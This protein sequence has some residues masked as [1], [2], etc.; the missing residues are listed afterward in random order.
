LQK[1]QELL[2][3]HP[4]SVYALN[5]L[6]SLMNIVLNETCSAYTVDEVDDLVERAL[7]FA[8]EHEHTR[9]RSYLLRMRG[10]IAFQKGYYAQG[11]AYFRMAHE[12]TREIDLLAELAKYQIEVQRLGDAEE[13]LALM[14]QQNDARFG[15]DE[16]QLI[17]S[18]EMLENA[19]REAEQSAE[20]GAEQGDHPQT[21][22]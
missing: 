6:Q 10:L 8:T 13:T 1:S 5:G 22:E 17:L 14:E 4:A 20:Q 21:V 18:R 16:Y 9:N 7:D 11:Y 19:K 12:L 15:I 2:E 3:R